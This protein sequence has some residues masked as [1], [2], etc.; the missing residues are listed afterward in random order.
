MIKWL[1][2]VKL[3]LSVVMLVCGPNWPTLL[4]FYIARLVTQGAI[5][6]PF[7]IYIYIERER[8]RVTQVLSLDLKT[9]ACLF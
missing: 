4:C 3:A 2:Y 5:N 8:E 9:D 6:L 1:F 7:K